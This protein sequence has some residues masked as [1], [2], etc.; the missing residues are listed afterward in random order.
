MDDEIIDEVEME[1]FNLPEDFKNIDTL[2]IGNR[3]YRIV[4]AEPT[5]ALQYSLSKKLILRL[6]SVESLNFSKSLDDPSAGR[7]QFRNS[8][9]G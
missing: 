3:E 2:A 9:P 1:Q 6:N 8:Q 5:H 7:I 4:R